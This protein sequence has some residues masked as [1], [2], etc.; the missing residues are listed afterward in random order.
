MQDRY[1]GDVGD[2]GKYGLLR[3][4]TCP[5][6]THSPLALGMCWYLVPDEGHNNDGRHTTYLEEISKDYRSCD[7]GLFD[8]LKQIVNAGQRNREVSA[9]EYA[10]LFPSGTTYFTERLEY[11]SKSREDRLGHRAAWVNEGFMKTRNADL[12]FFDPDNGIETRT[13]KKHAQNG[14]KYVYWDEIAPFQERCQ[15]VV[16]YHHLGRRGLHDEQI[17][18]RLKETTAR[19]RYGK[20]AIALRFHRGTSRAFIIVPTNKHRGIIGEAVKKLLDSS[21]RKHFDRVC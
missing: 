7:E 10:G 21:W 17:R 18:L 9:I 8:A 20:N 15:S 16:I 11:K 13:I 3:R 4:F 2:F 5:K 6:F 1:V 19:L 14:P 12:V